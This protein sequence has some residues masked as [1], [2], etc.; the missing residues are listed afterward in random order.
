MNNP[1]LF[2]LLNL[3]RLKIIAQDWAQ[4][5]PAIESLP[6]Y[7]GRGRSMLASYV[8]VAKATTTEDPQDPT[9]FN[10]E[11]SSGFKF[12]IKNLKIRDLRL[13]REVINR[14]IK[15]AQLTKDEAEQFPKEVRQ[16]KE[17][18]AQKKLFLKHTNLD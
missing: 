18:Y 3:T 7:S 2:P 17:K 1:D 5:Y 11:S 14:Y 10:F 4:R 8:V 6:L 15:K 16:F 9:D 13:E 12:R